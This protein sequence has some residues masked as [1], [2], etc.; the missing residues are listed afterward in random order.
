MMDDTGDNE[1]SKYSMINELGNVYVLS[2]QNDGKPPYDGTCVCAP[3]G[4]TLRI[5]LPLGSS[6]CVKSPQL[7]TNY[8]IDGNEFSRSK[9]HLISR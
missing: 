8:P 9:F 7:Y 3:Q 2:L 6:L 5:V 4:H 1:G